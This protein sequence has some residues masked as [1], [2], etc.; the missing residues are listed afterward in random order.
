[1]NFYSQIC[2]SLS[3][4]ISVRLQ[5]RRVLVLEIDIHESF[6]FLLFLSFLLCFCLFCFLLFWFLGGLF[7]L[8]VFFLVPF[9]CF[10]VFFSF[11]GQVKLSSSVDVPDHYHDQTTP[12]PH[13]EDF[14]SRSLDLHI[15][16]RLYKAV[17]DPKWDRDS[18]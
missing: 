2:S 11:V 16:P 18:G 8:L 14:V 10:V 7:Q 4:D 15:S 3:T 5:V 13:L 1:M 9:W 12:P 17:F 6:F